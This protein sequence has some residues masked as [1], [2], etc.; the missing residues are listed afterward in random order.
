MRIFRLGL[1]WTGPRI[2]LDYCARD[3]VGADRWCFTGM[4][5]GRAV[6][7]LRNVLGP[8]QLAHSVCICC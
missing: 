6:H 4:R 2:D 3:A 8:H 5:V 7:R 1:L